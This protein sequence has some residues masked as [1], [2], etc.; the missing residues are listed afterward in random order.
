MG[1]HNTA[2]VKSHEQPLPMANLVQLMVRGEQA[3]AALLLFIILGTM[4]TQVF[5]RYVFG[6]PFTWSEEVA[7]L[8]LIWLT[9][10]SAAFVMAQGR[11]IAVDMVSS[12]VSPRM[13]FFIECLSYLVVTTACL[14]LL[15]GGAKFVWYVGKV[16]SPALG[17]P[18]SWWYGAG[19][20][21]LLLIAVHSLI[22]LLQVVLTG[23]PIPRESDVEE[24]AFH[25]EM[26]EGK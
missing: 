8:S 4:A 21:G 16:G 18:K 7:R 13:N 15:I 11:H 17:V 26:G 22:N 12:R 5:A 3:I 6:A 20:M 2:N 14:L 23:K 9:F 19:G 24:E 10:I 25:L 1:N